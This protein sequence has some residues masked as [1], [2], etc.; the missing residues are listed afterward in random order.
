MIE[1]KQ[2]TYHKEI[3]LCELHEMGV[4]KCIMYQREVTAKNF[5]LLS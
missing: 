5:T 2:D 4:K 3:H 1:N